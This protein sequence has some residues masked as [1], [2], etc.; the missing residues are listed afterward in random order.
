MNMV[1]E[2]IDEFSFKASWEEFTVNFTHYHESNG[3]SFISTIDHFFC[4]RELN[5]KIIDCGVI[6]HPSNLSDNRPI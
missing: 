2:F 1:N 3:V 4:N 5:D 6:P